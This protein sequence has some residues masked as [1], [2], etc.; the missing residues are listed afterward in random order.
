MQFCRSVVLISVPFIVLANGCRTSSLLSVPTP[1]GVTDGSAIGGANGAEARRLGALTLFAKA[2]GTGAPGL[3]VGSGMLADE[4]V[5][6]ASDTRLVSADSRSLAIYGVSIL[7]GQYVSDYSYASLQSARLGAL[8][9][10]RALAAAA[11]ASQQ[12]K[13][14]QMFAI[15]GY[16]ETMLAEDYCSGIP[17]STSSA[18]GGVTFGV[19][20]ATDS[21]LSHAVTEFDSAL[22][23][24]VGNDSVT[25]LARIGRAR[26]RLDQGQYADA[27]V[28]VATVPTAFQYAAA[29]SQNP[30]AALVSSYAIGAY[31]FYRVAD[32]KGINGL[33]YIGAADPRTPVDSSMG[34][35][36]LGDIE[37][38]P[39]KF[40]PTA[41]A[42]PVA[43]G[44]EARLIEA[45]AAYRSGNEAGSAAILNALR[46]DSAETGV[47]GLFPIPSD[48]TTAASPSTQLDVLFRERAFWL[49][50]TAH[51]L[52]DLRRL[53]RQYG[54]DVSATFPTGPYPLATRIGGAPA[55]FGT[56]VVFPIQAIESQN[57]N[58][59]GCLSRAP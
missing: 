25:N 53:V 4:F 59:H 21:L 9:A 45:E 26:V 6:G 50:G 31:P 5:D 51:R 1:A 8:D 55:T 43:Q 54:R 42:L 10:A 37:Y 13:V 46:A 30:A 3:L 58:F 49:F 39:A 32:R 47:R 23:H 33:N 11:P 7:P 35:D 27:A 44:L 28:T 22:A 36:D 41:N 2:Y 18:A 14:G 48:S 40:S 29:A 20:I 38:Y 34:T 17:L 15:A 16:T 12:W 19:P 56:D 57:P 52:G 24:A